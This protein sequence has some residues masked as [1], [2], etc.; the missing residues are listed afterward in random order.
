MFQTT[1]YSKTERPSKLMSHRFSDDIPRLAA[2]LFFT[3]ALLFSLPAPAAPRVATSDWTVAETMTAMGHPPVS[4]ADR[5]VYDT[6]VNH[7][8]LPAA[9]KEAGLRFQPNLERLY[10]IKPDF[11]VQSSWYAAAKSQFEKIAPV[12]EVDF[13]TAKGIEYAHTVEATR[14]LG[15]IIGDPA[16]AEKLIAGTENLFARAKPALS[17][18]RGRPFAVVQFADVVFPSRRWF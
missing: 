13:G 9:V 2:R 3:S 5:R 4:V 6:W 17:A 10:Q 18:Y 7:P 15:K 16:A 14:R 8:P 12:R 1:L 11:F